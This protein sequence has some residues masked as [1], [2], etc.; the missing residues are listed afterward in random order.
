MCSC[1][2]ILS[3]S[4]AFSTLWI[5][6]IVASSESARIDTPVWTIL[7]VREEFGI[8]ESLRIESKGDIYFC[9]F[10]AEKLLGEKFLHLQNGDPGWPLFSS[11]VHQLQRLKGDAQKV[12]TSTIAEHS[13]AIS[14]RDGPTSDPIYIELLSNELA[15]QRIGSNAGIASF[16]QLLLEETKKNG[17][18]LANSSGSIIWL[19]PDASTKL[20]AERFVIQ[21]PKAGKLLKYAG[22]FLA[23]PY[24]PE[25]N[26]DLTSMESISNI[27]TERFDFAVWKLKKEINKQ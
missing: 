10:E 26:L 19:P 23:T 16:L 1:K 27:Q 11:F 15:I 22:K 24:P 4:I 13:P 18:A 21:D 20:P 17:H 12:P 9:Q 2:K 25:L 6:Q 3:F 8:F 14:P 5:S 7:V